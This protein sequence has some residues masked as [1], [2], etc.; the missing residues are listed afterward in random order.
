MEILNGTPFPVDLVIWEDLQG[1]A[2]LTVIV[3]ATFEI[4]KG[5]AVV[6]ATQVPVFTSD[7]HYRE[8]LNA[9]VR[10]ES[11]KVP[12]KPLADIV[13]VGKAHAPGQRPVSQLDAMLRVGAVQKTIRVFGD[14]EWQFASRLAGVAVISSPK[15]FQTME[16]TYERAYGGLD[17][18]AALYCAENPLGKGFIG[19]KSA[20]SIHGK[21]LPNIEEP[22]HLIQSWDDHPRPVGFGF[23]GRG[24]M[25][26]LKHAGTYDERY[27][28]ERAPALP[29]DFS[30]ALFNGAHPDLQVQGYLHGDE[31]VELVNLSP[32]P[33]LKFNLPG[34]RPQVTLKKWTVPPEEWFEQ[35]ASE[36]RE[37]TLDQIPTVEE[38]VTANLDTLVLTPDE[39]M[40]YEVFRGVASLNGLDV[41]NISQ[42]KITGG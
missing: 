1:L 22:R 8:D 33:R 41:S 30:C 37:V 21:P 32:Q 4:Q 28:K 15:P 27:Q 5:K 18:N 10:F 36:E 3:K 25:P 35:N 39:G 23:Y 16:L 7:E 26:R 11:D 17:Q 13:L 12:V 6:A 20:E 29:T 9:P 19:R 14:R 40:F 42:I 38:A 34:I 24:W 31:P 2:K